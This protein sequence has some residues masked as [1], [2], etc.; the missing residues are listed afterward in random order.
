MACCFLTSFCSANAKNYKK[1]IFAFLGPVSLP[2][3]LPFLFN[4][5][6]FEGFLWGGSGSGLLG[7]NSEVRIRIYIHYAALKTAMSTCY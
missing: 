7:K 3:H 2:S 6:A 5:F 1:G 4:Y